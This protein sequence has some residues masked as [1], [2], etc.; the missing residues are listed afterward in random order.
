MGV[1][2]LAKKG[3]N[4][5]AAVP[6]R[7]EGNVSVETETAPTLPH[8]SFVG[9]WCGDGQVRGPAR[10]K[11]NGRLR[12]LPHYGRLKAANKRDLRTLDWYFDTKGGWEAFVKRFI[13][14]YYENR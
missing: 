1:G 13:K 10:R 3:I 6:M 2:R 8:R 9:R 7:G 5:A 4:P 14:Y 11:H 12:R